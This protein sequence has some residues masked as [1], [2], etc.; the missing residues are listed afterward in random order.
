MAYL[1]DFEI[2]STVTSEREL[3]GRLNLLYHEGGR[4]EETIEALA[5]EWRKQRDMIQEQILDPIFFAFRFYSTGSQKVTKD[6]VIDYIKN[7][8]T[9]LKRARDLGQLKEFENSPVQE[10]LDEYLDN[11]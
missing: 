8:Q 11:N 7:Y 10:L 5:A 6:L 2:I 4:S 1:N 3:N 9:S